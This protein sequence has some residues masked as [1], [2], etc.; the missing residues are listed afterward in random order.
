MKKY[1][2]LLILIIASSILFG[3][4]VHAADINDAQFVEQDVPATMIAGKTYQVSITM[5]NNG[6]TTWKQEPFYSYRL[7]SQN[8]TNNT[9]WGNIIYFN[10]IRWPKASRIELSRGEKVLPGATKKFFFY[11]TAPTSP[12]V[13]NFQW[14][15]VREWKQWFGDFTPN[16][17]VKVY[18]EP[19][20][21]G[22]NYAHYLVTNCKLPNNDNHGIIYEYHLSGVRSKVQEQLSTMKLNGV[23]SLRFILWF[24]TE[25]D[26]MQRY[27]GVIPSGTG[28]IEEPYRS[29]LTNFV[30]DIKNAGFERLTLSY[31]AMG[32][33]VP[34]LVDVNNTF[35]ENWSFIKDTRALVKAY[36]PTDTRIDLN[37][38]LI[39]ETQLGIRVNGYLVRMYKRYIENFGNGD[40]TVS[41]IGGP[42]LA[43]RMESWIN[44]FSLKGL[45]LPNWFEIHLYVEYDQIF[46][47][48]TAIEDLYKRYR[49]TQP[50]VIGETWYNDKTTAQ[51]INNF[52]SISIIV[53][54]PEAHT[55][56][57]KLEELIQ[58]PIYKGVG[59]EFWGCSVN[60]P[61]TVDNY[62]STF[63][64]PI[65]SFP[66]P[67][68]RPIEQN[69]GYLIYKYLMAFIG[70]IF[71]KK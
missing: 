48:L 62:I 52:F 33:N 29:N 42:G 20:L 13:Y 56:S 11:V 43:S 57:I 7:G 15:M 5:K 68:F 2:L 45:S 17:A 30:T 51:K 4:V 6:S 49:L 47:E 25:V 53:D 35:E 65:T 70:L 27:W 9:I 24:Q 21:I 60:P 16:V 8:P 44:L 71:Q 32:R 61:Y 14:K 58:W 69:S 28:K 55:P 36:G 19:P 46:G 3:G 12:G 23:E 54:N 10:N 37:N 50:I 64:T 41:V 59:S 67:F 31:G 34:R 38:E 66:A 26:S 40:M 18:I 63:S 22:T 39:N 1:F